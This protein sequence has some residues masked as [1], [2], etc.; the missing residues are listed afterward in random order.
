[1]K[2]Q[3]GIWLGKTKF[4]I[5]IASL[6]LFA[7]I[8][9]CA[10]AQTDKELLAKIV[11]ENQ[12]A[13]DALV[14]YPAE[15]RQDILEVALYPEALIKLENMQASTGAAFKKAVE[16]YSKETQEIVW[17]MT[18]YPGLVRRIARESGGSKA[19]I[20]R[21][22]TGYPEEIHN[23]ALRA[24][25][26]HFGVLKQIDELNQAAES[27]FETMISAY[28]TK[29][30]AALH[31]LLELPEVLSLL[32]EN[33]RLTIL[34]GDLYRKEPAW[35]LHQADSLNLVVARRNAQEVED[36]KKSLEENP[37]AKEALM[38]AAQ[39]YAEETGYDD[40]LYDNDLYDGDVYDEGQYER[41]VRIVER[42]YHHY[43]YWFGYPSWYDYP[44]WR[45][46]PW[47]WDWGFY[48]PGSVRTIVVIGL[49]SYHF[50]NWYFYHPWHHDR[51]YHLSD[52]F[53]RHHYRHHNSGGSITT[54]VVV[55]QQRHRGIISDDWLRDDGRR[56]DRF[57]EFSRLE[58]NLD[59][60]NRSNP[61]KKLDERDYLDR[62]TG[63]YPELSKVKPP[64]ASVEQPAT[65]AKPPARD[66]RDEGAP[67]L[68]KMPDQDRKNQPAPD[69]RS[70]PGTP[71]K[72]KPDTQPVTPPTRVPS[73]VQ[74]EI[75]K[76]REHH[77]TTLE[78]QKTKQSA[79]PRREPAPKVTAPPKRKA[80]TKEPPKQEKSRRD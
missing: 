35:V 47:W 77:E 38:A 62:N 70:K 5:S 1:M 21:V 48:Y 49:P 28:P 46:Y 58:A 8:S 36:W 3:T 56:A 34:A 13:V 52:H 33:I 68:K 22:L 45:P 43:P 66:M 10:Y 4:L 31:R 63:R 73:T 53:V 14:L 51:W 12:K 75:N 57:R 55:W 32:T 29:T 37:Q 16:P 42:H 41:P 74:P 15:T 67:E 80:A 2:N 6:I 78:K 23:K 17:D 54:G 72:T 7:G 61:D 27:A 19:G 65:R 11:E 30:K 20:D 9:T 39:T 71:S 25:M 44:R 26:D 79:E 18:R 59:K 76:G 50:T 40:D 69:T 24:G 64:K 60:Y